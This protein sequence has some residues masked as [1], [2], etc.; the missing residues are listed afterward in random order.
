LTKIT[1]LIRSLF[2]STSAGI[3]DLVAEGNRKSEKRIF[4][5][6]LDSKLL[7]AGVV[8]ISLY[9]LT[10]PFIC[11]WLGHDYLLGKRFLLIYLAMYGI[12]MTRGTVES[13]L[14]AHGMFQ[15]IWAPIAEAAV[16]IGLSILFQ[17]RRKAAQE[18]AEEG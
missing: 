18:E 14:A 15:D 8:I 10:Q 6:I 4:W 13:F 2:N 7:V 9:F 12:L 17:R 1:D 16:N 3:G 5:E 11:A